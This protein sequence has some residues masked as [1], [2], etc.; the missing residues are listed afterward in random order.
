[1]PKHE[2]QLTLLF[3]HLNQRRIP[4]S[5]GSSVRAAEWWRKPGGKENPGPLR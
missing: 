5:V 2:P 1:M 3:L 4:E